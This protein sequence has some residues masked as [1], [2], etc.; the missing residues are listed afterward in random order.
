MPI[1][2]Q[3]PKKYSRRDFLRRAT[4]Y[5]GGATAVLLAGGG[6]AGWILRGA[7]DGQGENEMAERHIIQTSPFDQVAP[8]LSR[9]LLDNLDELPSFSEPI[10][11]NRFA[12]TLAVNETAPNINTHQMLDIAW[13]SST[14]SVEVEG[15]HV[16]LF[17]VVG[18]LEYAVP[19]N[20][21]YVVYSNEL[22]KPNMFLPLNSGD[23]SY[24]WAVEPESIS[25]SD[26]LNK[27][28][29]DGQVGVAAVPLQN[30]HEDTALYLVQYHL[31]DGSLQPGKAFQ[32]SAQKV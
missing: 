4:P 6:V 31:R 15:K 1:K 24:H 17:K 11:A 21:P 7:I 8:D 18:D 22:S 9:L 16:V 2:E 13:G 14:E 10:I 26:G 29:Y 12:H 32:L 5:A 27:P 25:I 23:Y 20:V 3:Q 30:V 19:Q 28:R